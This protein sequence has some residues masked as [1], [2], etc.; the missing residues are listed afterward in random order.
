MSDILLTEVNASYI[1]ITCEEHI[2]T[3]LWEYF[4]FEAP[5]ARFD[6]RVKNRVWDGKLHLYNK[7]SRQIYRGLFG[8]LM[9]W[10]AEHEYHV[11]LEGDFY[12]AK[13]P[14]EDFVDSLDLPVH[15][16]DRW[17]Q[18]DSFEEAVKM[19]RNITLLS[20]AGG[21]SLII[22]MLMRYHQKKT[23]IIV[24]TLGLI[25]QMKRHFGEYGYDVEENVH[26]IYGGI[27]KTTDKHVTIA[28]WQS[29]YQQPKEWYDDYELVIGDEVHLFDAKSLQGIMVNARFAWYRYGFTGTLKESK[30]HHLVLEG[31]FG[32]VFQPTSTIELAEQGYIARPKINVL[33]FDHKKEY[34]EL[35][36]TMDYQ[37]EMKLICGM[38]KRN[39]YIA[40]LALNLRGNTLVLFR[41]LEEHGKPLMMLLKAQNGA[42]PL[43]YVDGNTEKDLREQIRQ[44][45][46]GG[47]TSINICSYG[48]FSTGIDIPNLDNIVFASPYKS[49]VKV[50]QSIGRGLRLSEGK[51][52][53]N[54]YDLVDDLTWRGEENYTLKHYMDRIRYYNEEE[55]DYKQYRI[56]I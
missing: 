18:K 55:F 27:T 53:C 49:K 13:A 16:K 54:I 9:L 37:E 23:L 36:Y 32:P 28:T 8:R 52:H 29:I 25:D 45:I 50:L 19:K 42:P 35:A 47:K 31:L 7:K 51:T 3:E 38:E 4:T 6:P 17:Y 5:N 11:E 30:C 41:F 1:R 24:N 20:T 46:I 40:N 2:E 10:A 43:H 12:R 21:K 14:P 15:I 22:Y 26:C 34:R 44:F 33:I 39:H 48:V 56:E